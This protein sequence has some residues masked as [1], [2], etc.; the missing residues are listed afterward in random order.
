MKYF[1]FIIFI[2][3]FAGTSEAQ[4]SKHFIDKTLRLDYYHCGNSG[5]EHFF[6]DELIQEPYWAGSQTNLIDTKGYGT[7]LLE[8]RIAN[9]GELI[10]SRGYCT[11]FGEWQTTPEAKITG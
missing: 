4:F 7:Q 8:V 3:I 6:F 1:L 10:Y 9:T 2:V 11:L 5:Y